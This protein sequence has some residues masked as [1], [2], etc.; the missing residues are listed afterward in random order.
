MVVPV[1]DKHFVIITNL[2]IILDDIFDDCLA[3]PDVSMKKRI[4]YKLGKAH[5]KMLFKQ[6]N[7]KKD[8]K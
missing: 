6:L 7:I 4:Q 3:S 8:K 5:L 2:L 1:K